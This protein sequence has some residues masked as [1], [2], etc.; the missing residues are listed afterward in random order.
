ME[1]AG[2][3]KIPDGSGAPRTSSG[4]KPK[5]VYIEKLPVKGGAVE[6]PADTLP[7]CVVMLE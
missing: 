3:G 4:P 5:A 7:G 1:Y 2:A 6:S